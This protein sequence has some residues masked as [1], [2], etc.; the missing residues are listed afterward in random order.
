MRSLPTEHTLLLAGREN[1]SRGYQIYY[2][3][4]THMIELYLK[5]ETKKEMMRA[6]EEFLDWARGYIM[7]TQKRNPE[8]I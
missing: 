5:G 4:L 1:G 8:F 2:N 3:T 6:E 7:A